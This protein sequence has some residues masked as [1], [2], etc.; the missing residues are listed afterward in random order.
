MGRIGS[1][2]RCLNVSKRPGITFKVR[3]VARADFVS[4]TLKGVVVRLLRYKSIVESP[5]SVQL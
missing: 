3:T 4:A 2:F 1:F 5:S